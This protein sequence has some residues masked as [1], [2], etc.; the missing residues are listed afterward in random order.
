LL[1]AFFV[2][3]AAGLAAAF[4]DLAVVL[5]V[6]LCVAVLA[7]LAAIAVPVKRNADAI[8]DAISFFI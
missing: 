7:V 1:A 2:V 4:V 5:T 3:F 6:V 8:I